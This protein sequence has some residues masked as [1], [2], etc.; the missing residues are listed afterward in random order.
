MFEGL[1]ESVAGG[2]RDLLLLLVD[3]FVQSVHDVVELVHLG[4]NLLVDVVDF[5]VERVELP[6]QRH[7]FLMLSGHDRPSLRDGPVGLE[8]CG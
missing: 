4:V 2:S 6:M 8:G 5:L 1:E 7:E 3:F